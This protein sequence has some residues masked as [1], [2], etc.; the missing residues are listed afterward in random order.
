MHGGE[1]T[2]TVA[3]EQAG[4]CRAQRR[5]LSRGDAAGGVLRL[6]GRLAGG[7]A[8][9]WDALLTN[10]TRGATAAGR[11][12]ASRR[13]RLGWQ[14]VHALTVWSSTGVCPVASNVAG[15]EWVGLA[16]MTEHVVSLHDAWQRGASQLCET[17]ASGA[18]EQSLGRALLET[19]GVRGV[20]SL[21]GFRQT[22]GD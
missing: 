14:L 13:T 3:E 12:T 7:R 10:A 21:L 9:D 15:A 16:E 5:L 2:G 17:I 8:V 20:L 18:H 4:G 11:S 1:N 6:Q 22:L 19:L